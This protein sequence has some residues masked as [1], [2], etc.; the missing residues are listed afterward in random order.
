MR[1]WRQFCATA[2]ALVAASVGA[3]GTNAAA[4]KVVHP[5]GACDDRSWVAGTV[6]YCHGVLVYR[7]YVYD[8]YGA[9][10]GLTYPLATSTATLDPPAG[11]QRYPAG[12]VNTADL[13]WLKLWL[14]GGR[15]HV[16]AQLNAL[17]HSGS[18]TLAVAIDT[19]N[20]P[21]TGGG[22]WGRLDV[23]S[24]G[25][26]EIAFFGHGDTAANTIDGTM[27]AP[28]SP[29]WRV[30]AATAQTATGTVMNVAFRGPDERADYRTTPSTSSPY[31]YTGQGAWFEDNQAHALA[32][33][34]I[35]QFGFTASTVA[36]RRHATWT[37][38]VGPGLHEH[39]YTSAY[40]L[41]PG[42]GMSYTGETTAGNG[43]SIP[44]FLP[45]L[46]HF[47][48]RWQP[49]GI[50]VPAKPGPH[51]L[52]FVFH[53]NNTS[54]SSLINQPGM[55]QVLGENLNRILV[56]PLERGPN[57]WGSEAAER[58]ILDV[59]HDV[60]ANYDIDRTRVFSGG[61]SVGGYVALRMAEL[62]PQLF[63]G[64]IDWVGVA[65]DDA[66]G[67]PLQGIVHIS[68]GA[69][70][71]VS[72]Y[73]GNLLNIPTAMLYAA[74]DEFVT[75]PS[76]IHLQQAFAATD[77]PY[78]WYLHTAE[79]FTLAILDN[80]QKEARDTAGLR[81]DGDPSHIIYRTDSQLDDPAYGIRHDSAY[82][83][84]SI[85]ERRPGIEKIELT[86]SACGRRVLA[87]ATGNTIGL[88]PVPWT[89]VYRRVVS[90]ILTAP[91]ATIVGTLSNVRSL[92]IDATETC[93]DHRAI[94]FSI[95]TDGPTTIT[96]SDRR[97]LV[98]SGA[99]PHTVLLPAPRARRARR[100]RA[101]RNG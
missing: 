55:Q 21:A 61:Y 71:D 39:V 82:W 22:Q 24:S 43:G 76:A 47:F 89:A 74:G 67:T 17:F 30:Q 72:Q 84:S 96:L 40:T 60:E 99:G 27:P 33:G 91:Q 9:D 31:P 73:V 15:L 100:H 46:F 51:G 62:Y 53:G 52:Q 88:D 58:D 66:N 32:T 90:S 28:R 79:H 2:A 97:R 92:T 38:P 35:S 68:G 64:V 5:T 63:A 19:D 98:L 93:I 70:G 65:G 59:L 48:G 29:R 75:L 78:I 95:D 20:D 80:W 25:W 16:H 56:V 85:R 34:D 87:D 10:L 44:G 14:A 37:Q 26:D 81:L 45:Q 12:D 18:T 49:Y 54:M 8:D 11:D 50:Y 7:D 4:G 41:P 36:M 1:P 42:K 94:D 83:L 13:V 6:A 23:R 69:E 86:N 57:G 77:D 3:A 101:R